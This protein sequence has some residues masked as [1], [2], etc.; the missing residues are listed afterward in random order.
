MWAHMDPYRPGL[1][2]YE[3]ETLQEKHP[4][5]SLNASLSKIVFL[6]FHMAF[7]DNLNVDFRFLAEIRFRTIMKLPQKGSSRT[8]TCSFGTS[9]TLP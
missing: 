1:G 9:V 7:I 3:G 5:F 2:P 6:N 4:L 8:K